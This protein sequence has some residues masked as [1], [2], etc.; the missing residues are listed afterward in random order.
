MSPSE[1][2]QLL[3]IVSLAFALRLYVFLTTP[4][5]G[6]D[7]Y[8]FALAA[9]HFSEG[10]FSEGLALCHP[11]Y[12][13]LVAVLSSVTGEYE[14]SGESVSIFFGTLTVLPLYFLTRNLFG[15]QAALLSALF[16]AIN[17][18]HVRLSADVII[19]PTFLFFFTTGMWLGWRAVE[20]RHWYFFPLVGASVLLAYLT[21]IEGL[22]VLVAVLPWLFLIDRKNL[23]QEFLRRVSTLALLLVFL[24]PI[25]PLTHFIRQS[26]GI[27]EKK[28]GLKL[29][30][31]MWH[32]TA[33][34]KAHIVIGHK[35][36]HV[37]TINEV[38]VRAI[39]IEKG[40]KPARV[41]LAEWKEEGRYHRIVLFILNKYV[42]TTYIPCTIFILVGLFRLSRP[43][44]IR[45]NTGNLSAT[46]KSCL[47]T[48]V[49]LLATVRLRLASVDP[50]GE[51]FIL[52]F[53]LFYLAILYRVATETYFMSGRYL[54][55]MTILSF[56]WAGIGILKLS[57][58][59]A[60]WFTSLGRAGLFSYSKGTMLLVA[61]LLI[62]TLPKD[63][64]VKRTA[65]ESLSK[66]AGLWIKHL[67]SNK[68]RPVILGD[69]RTAFYAEADR[70]P[71]QR[72]M[73]YDS[74]L[75]LAKNNNVDY[76][77]FY[78]ERFWQVNRETFERIE[79]E[80]DFRFVKEWSYSDGKKGRHLRLYR[81]VRK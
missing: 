4:V 9:R 2:K 48:M 36:A 55:P 18:T 5:I 25:I 72:E 52:G 24:T 61:S 74:L 16:L 29:S 12:P 40:S 76:L 38:G 21:R 69:E 33:H 63:L 53:L 65:G 60:N 56:V 20:S 28:T 30:Q 44:S 67:H 78:K 58:Y 46:I 19:E 71:I 62:F 49:D 11:L 37:P 31:N 14:V 13:L 17:P 22:V 39:I 54:L 73:D 42:K 59:I 75:E 66:E 68:T 6:T 34:P 7:G 77:A 10:K 64:K 35:K 1:K 15:H 79:R 26:S 3:C 45:V 51:F 27:I 50:R 80:K 8:V 70:I 43:P 32:I 23:W 41:R 57:E 81:F 47:S